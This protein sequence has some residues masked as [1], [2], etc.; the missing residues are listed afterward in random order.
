MW[1]YHECQF[2]QPQ[3]T[4]RDSCLHLGSSHGALQLEKCEFGLV[5][6]YWNFTTSISQL[7]GSRQYPKFESTNSYFMGCSPL[8]DV[9]APYFLQFFLNQSPLNSTALI[10][11]FTRARL[12][13]VSRSTCD[14]GIALITIRPI[15][16]FYTQTTSLRLNWNG[17]CSPQWYT[18][19]YCLL[20]IV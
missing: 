3:G 12:D 11:Y 9:L 8:I 18:I 13:V 5:L 1:H 17:S 20:L 10:H 15:A 2:I 16:F 4:P 19:Y 7:S 6:F 14:I